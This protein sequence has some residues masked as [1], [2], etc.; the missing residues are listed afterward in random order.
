[1]SH[2]IFAIL[3]YGEDGLTY[4][5]E[6]D[7]LRAI[8]VMLVILYHGGFEIFGRTGWFDNGD[9]G[10]DV[11]FVISGYLITSIILKELRE[12]GAFSYRNFYERR[13]R[14]ILPGLFA[15]LLAIFP[16][17]FFLLDGLDLDFFFM[18]VIASIA[19]CSNILFYIVGSDLAEQGAE[20][21]PLIHTWSLGIEEQF[22][23]I[24]P[25]VLLLSLRFSPRV[26]LPV[27]IFLFFISLQ[28]SDF[29]A[30]RNQ[31]FNFFM[32]SSRFWELLAGSL[33]AYLEQ[34]HGAVRHRLLNLV[35]PVIGLCMIIWYV[36]LSGIHQAVPNYVT[37]IPVLGA[38]FIIAFA[39]RDNPV[40]RLL[41]TKPFVA[42]GLM[43]Y[44][45]YLWHWPVFFFFKQ[46]QPAPE[47]LD[48][49]GWVG[50][51]FLLSGLTYYFVEQPFRNRAFISIKPFYILLA[52]VAAFIIL[53]AVFGAPSKHYLLSKID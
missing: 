1:M 52:L 18:T 19:F 3:L 49:L 30:D 51:S 47:N 43:S 13:T 29:M 17:Y 5:P 6:I 14:R 34:E 45:L 12:T 46:I 53:L 38:A 44:S 2:A 21:G 33:L 26:I 31:N 27:L 32:L 10:V 4:R 40:G 35:M 28:F 39:S 11:F 50:L 16:V 42:V 37:V 9:I 15:V 23:I 25:V 36:L 7:G 41:G 22:Y 8:A 24:F 48:R 20:V